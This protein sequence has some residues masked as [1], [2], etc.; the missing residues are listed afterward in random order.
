M[1]RKTIVF[2]SLG[3]V[4]GGFAGYEYILPPSA[5]CP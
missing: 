2:L 3:A 1:T 5:L 4:A